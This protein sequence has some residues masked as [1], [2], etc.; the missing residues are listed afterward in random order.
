MAKPI[1]QII[2]AST[3]PRRAGLPIAQW[4]RRRAVAH[5][6]FD[7][8][9]VDLAEVNLPFLD[10]P[11]HPRLRQYTHK[12]TRDW[13]ATIERGDAYVFVTPEYNHSFPATL[14]NAIDYLHHEWRRKPVGFVSYGG[15]AAGT[16]A[17]Q[18]LKQ[19]VTAL[20]MV[21]VTEAVAI[22]FFPQFLADGVLHPN[23]VMNSAA[24]DMLTELVV[25][26]AALA[27]LRAPAG[28]QAA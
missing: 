10:E 25:V 24:D 19:V 12:H 18:A 5:G 22:P 13:S 6:G 20:K 21:P 15:V 23:D 27:T 1:L 14:K 4:F 16:R 8:E 7:V 3:R 2:V 28:A 9:L 11:D 26:N 17:V